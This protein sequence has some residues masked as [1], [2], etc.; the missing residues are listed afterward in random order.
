MT[1]RIAI[2]GLGRIGRG[3]LRTWIEDVNGSAKNHSGSSAIEIVAANDL[4]PLE[5]IAH[6]LEFDSVY[7]RLG[8]PVRVEGTELAVADA[9]IAVTAEP[10]PAALPWSEHRVDTVVEATGRFREADA[11]R[12]HL[13]AGAKRV[14]VSAPS[15]GADLTI[16]MGVNDDQLTA[17]HEI[18][19]NGSCT[20]NALAPIAKVLNDFAG[21]EHGFVT[22][23]HA[24]TGDQMLVDGVHGDLRRAR[25]AGINIVPTSTGAAKAIG[26]VIPELDGKLSGDALRVP[27]PVGSIVELNAITSREVSIDELRAAFEEAAA[28]R[29]RGVLT[30]EDAPLVSSD[31]VGN[32]HSSI[33]DAPLLRAEGVHVKVVAWYDNEWS[34]SRRMLDVLA[35]M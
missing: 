35:R 31:I 18:V 3:I 6:L 20:T 21:I 7:G 10:D 25:A 33:V 4:A 14:L 32:Q 17:E 26:K 19:S 28:G 24:Y 27:V 5:T 16:V 13:T 34:F 30:V 23:V 2:N 22:T 12:A 9:R 11:A 15:K 8:T 29:M 1:R